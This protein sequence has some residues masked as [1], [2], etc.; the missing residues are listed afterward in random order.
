MD[1]VADGLAL[2]I[3]AAHAGVALLVKGDMGLVGGKGKAMPLI[4]AFGF[5]D[6]IAGNRMA[7]AAILGT[8]AAKG[9]IVVVDE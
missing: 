5:G 4:A 3:V 7:I 9:W 1:R 8:V 2:P 6:L